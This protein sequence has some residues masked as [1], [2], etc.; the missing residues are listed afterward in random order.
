MPKLIGNNSAHHAPQSSFQLDMNTQM[1]LRASEIYERGG[2]LL[3]DEDMLE[4]AKGAKLSPDLVNKVIDTWVNEEYLQKID[5]C[6]YML[7]N[8]YPEARESLM[9]AGETSIKAA[10]RGRK[11]KKVKNAKLRGQVL[12]TNLEQK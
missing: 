4:I 1:R 10:E 5:G 7:G 11:R 8:R 12:K 6:I 9:V 2:I 3:N